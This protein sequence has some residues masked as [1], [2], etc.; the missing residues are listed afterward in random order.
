[1][2]FV[3]RGGERRERCAKFEM[4]TLNYHAFF[5]GKNFRKK[6][7]K[8][9]AE[10]YIKFHARASDLASHHRYKESAHTRTRTRD[11]GTYKTHVRGRLEF[12]FFF[13]FLILSLASSFGEEEK[14]AEQQQTAP[15]WETSKENVVPLKQGRKVAAIEE[16]ANV[17]GKKDERN[18]KVERE[19]RCV[20]VSLPFFYIFCGERICT[21]YYQRF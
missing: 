18:E 1:V 6:K 10:N 15:A 14:M 12:S 19:K 17:V 20:C 8:N 21:F 7:E 4:Q 13:S 2:F 5:G 11:K 16:N 3:L 9:H